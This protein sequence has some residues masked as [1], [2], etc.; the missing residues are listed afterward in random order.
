M[1]VNLDHLIDVARDMTEIQKKI[2]EDLK[3]IARLLRERGYYVSTLEIPE[4][5]AEENDGDR[6]DNL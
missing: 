3:E 5:K 2:E 6:K 1:S 4:K